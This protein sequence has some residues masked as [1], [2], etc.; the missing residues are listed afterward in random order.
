MMLQQTALHAS[1]FCSVS[2]EGGRR[3]GGVGCNGKG[4]SIK[5][6]LVVRS[7]NF[8]KTT[9]AQSSYKR[10]GRGEVRKGLGKQGVY[11]GKEGEVVNIGDQPQEFVPEASNVFKGN[12]KTRWAIES[13]Q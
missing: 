6:L 1:I 3:E 12:R 4:N 7:H 2:Q 5:P 8:S 10:T 9:L 11:E 13:H